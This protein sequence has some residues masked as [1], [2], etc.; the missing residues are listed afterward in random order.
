MPFGAILVLQVLLAIHAARTGRMQPWLYII[1]FLPGIGCLLY[2]L[3]ELLP[4]LMGGRTGRR[5][6]AGV[7]QAANPGRNYRALARE[8]EIAPTV[9][10]RLR[11]AEECLGLNR[12]AEALGLLQGCLAGMYATDPAIRLNLARAHYATGDFAAAVQVLEDLARDTPDH[13]TT[14]GHLLYAMS[15][16]GAGRTDDA[17][18][19]YAALADRFLG[20]EVRYR[21]AA[22]LAQTGAPDAA[23][24]KYQEI[25]R[26]VDLQGGVY[27]RAQR[28]WYDAARRALA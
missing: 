20:E 15:L 27:R 16:E 23:Q 24:E 11:L 18:R 4:E 8:A 2:V 21:Y 5:V 10:N 17:L 25:I 26:R 3:V 9:H 13:R 7:V 14:P 12:G 6:T 28:A 1:I 19:E 22:L